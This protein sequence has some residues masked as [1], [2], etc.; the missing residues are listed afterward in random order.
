V[1]YLSLVQSV[2]LF[3]KSITSLYVLPFESHYNIVCNSISIYQEIIPISIFMDELYR[4]VNS[5][6]KAVGK[7][8]T[9]SYFLAFFILSSLTT[10]LL[11]YTD[12]MFLSV[13]TN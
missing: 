8:Y 13:F 2:I 10:I 11:V 5:V 4:W 1:K 12:E 9:S 6:S 3:V 7:S